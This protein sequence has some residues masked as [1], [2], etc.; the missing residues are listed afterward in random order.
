MNFTKVLGCYNKI[1]GDNFLFVCSLIPI[2]NRVIEVV[3]FLTIISNFPTFAVATFKAGGNPTL[4]CK[5][6]PSM[7]N[8]I[9]KLPY[10]SALI[11]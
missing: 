1:K 3:K 4:A 11:D 10:E 7:S 8:K 9:A 5:A 6:S 2:F